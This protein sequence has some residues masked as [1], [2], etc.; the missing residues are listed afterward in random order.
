MKV[1][2]LYMRWTQ[3]EVAL[4]PN[5]ARCKRDS[6]LLSLTALH[7]VRS[8]RCFHYYGFAYRNSD[9]CLYKRKTRHSPMNELLDH[10][11][12]SVKFIESQ[13]ILLSKETESGAFPKVLDREDKT[14]RVSK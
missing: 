4:C 5:Q 2:S 11:H 13:N 3:D 1:C 14:R 7:Q 12:A 9:V 8:R 6:K 10:F